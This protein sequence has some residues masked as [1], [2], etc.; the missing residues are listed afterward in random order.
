MLCIREP[1]LVRGWAEG[2]L[3]QVLSYFIKYLCTVNSLLPL[4][5]SGHAKDALSLA[6]MQEQTLQLE[7]QTKLKVCWNSSFVVQPALPGHFLCS[8][9]QHFS[10][11]WPVELC[12]DD[13]LFTLTG[14][15]SCHRTTEE[16]ADTGTSRRETENAQWRNKTASSSKGVRE[17]PILACVL[18]YGKGNNALIELLGRCCGMWLNTLMSNSV[19]GWRLLAY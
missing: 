10:I 18:L 6:Q 8:C 11:G 7:Q 2:W 17:K 3:D 5:I 9:H 14:V 13:S 4:L 12:C 15:W 19:K 16:W 1:H